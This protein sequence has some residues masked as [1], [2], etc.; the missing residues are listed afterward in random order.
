MRK[1]TILFSV[2]LVVCAMMITA[3]GAL[4][5]QLDK[6]IVEPGKKTYAE[7]T[8]DVELKFAKLEVA[9]THYTNMR[10][11]FYDDT[12]KEYTPIYYMLPDAK[13]QEVVDANAYY[14]DI[15]SDVIEEKKKYAELKQKIEKGYDTYED[16]MKLGIRL[17][18]LIEKI[19]LIMK[20][21]K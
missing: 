12:A 19:P 16:I 3:C 15:R 2:I 1:I 4:K 17:E 20:L 9:D 5:G 10:E 11:I 18:G 13:K 6:R 21:K 7:V 8:A 14:K